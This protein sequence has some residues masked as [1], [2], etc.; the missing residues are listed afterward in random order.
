MD[1]GL[2]SMA[3][4]TLLPLTA[5]ISDA[6]QTN[7]A[8][9]WVTVL[10]HNTHEHP[11]PPDAACATTTMITPLGC[12][13]ETYFYELSLTVTDPLQLATTQTVYIYPDCKGLL[14][15]PADIDHDGTVDG[16]DLGMLIGAWGATGANPADLN[17]D[18]LVDGAD[19]G[20]LIGAWG[21]C[22]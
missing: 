4:K 17:G 11:E 1:G 10:H 20:L 9:S 21:A 12:G 16:A 22:P 7:L 19:L 3:S 14:M 18:L 5:V 15:C 13:S 6:E 2:Y 8:C